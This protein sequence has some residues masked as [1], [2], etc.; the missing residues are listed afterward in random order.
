MKNNIDCP[1]CGAKPQQLET[2]G[3]KY[4]HTSNCNMGM[5]D[6]FRDTK[7]SK[8]DLAC[9][10]CPTMFHIKLFDTKDGDSVTM[11]CPIC[12]VMIEAEKV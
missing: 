5:A 4:D 9:T 10:R 3:V 1:S 12:W 11:E 8:F 7:G 6:Y 2:A